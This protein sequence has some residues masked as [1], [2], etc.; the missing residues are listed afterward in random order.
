M[1]DARIQVRCGGWWSRVRACLSA[2]IPAALLILNTGGCYPQEDWQR[3]I[4]AAA[5]GTLLGAPGSQGEPG[6][7]GAKGDPGERGPQGDQGEAGQGE[8]GAPGPQGLQGPQGSQGPP[9][10]SSQIVAQTGGIVAAVPGSRVVLDGS[11]TIIQA[12]SE[13]TLEDLTFFWIQVDLMDFPVEI[14]DADQAIAYFDLPEMNPNDYD[15]FN[16]DGAWLGAVPLQFRLTVTDP[17]GFVSTHD[18]FVLVIL[19]YEWP[20]AD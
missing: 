7:Q 16:G 2:A 18:T 9:G 14:Q 15:A 11:G 8:R 5:L 10:P 3:D 17:D 19:L 13:L 1:S 12:G 4:L 6:P 20:S